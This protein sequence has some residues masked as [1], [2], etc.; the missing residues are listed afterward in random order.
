MTEI[1]DEAF[2]FCVS[3]TSIILPE[4]VTKIG[5]NAFAHCKSLTSAAMYENVEIGDLA[6]CG[7]D[8]IQG[9]II[10]DEMNVKN[11]YN[12]INSLWIK[13]RF[14][15]DKNGRLLKYIGSDGMVCIPALVKTIGDSAFAGCK[16]IEFVTIP[17]GITEIGKA[18]F[19][20]CENLQSI[21]IPESVTK[22]SSYAFYECKSL[23]EIT[24]PESVN[25]IG[26]M[27]FYHC[28]S[29]DSVTLPEHIT[30]V[31]TLTFSGTLWLEGDFIIDGKGRLLKYK[32]YD[33]DV[34]V[35]DGVKIIMD[36]VFS[37]FSSIKSIVIPD[38]VEKI[39]AC[40]FSQCENLERVTLPDSFISL[41]HRKTCVLFPFNVK[42]SCF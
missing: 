6:F 16:K 13:F 23:Y 24:I 28:R 39:G 11:S 38:G 2:L 31:N 12:I 3:L 14:V 29:L 22:I 18:A 17:E 37:G 20:N 5:K 19:A 35:P 1:G 25:L 26:E 7:C 42:K 4:S 30:Q 8:N 9:I 32:G 10:A 36:G 21:T 40:V 41:I 33:S 15:M 34:V 27:A